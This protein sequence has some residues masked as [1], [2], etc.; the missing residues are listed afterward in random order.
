VLPNPQLT[1]ALRDWVDD[2]DATLRRVLAFLDLPYDPACE[3]F[4]EQDSR[5]RTASRQQVRQPV[6]AR[7]L[8]RWP[9][10]ASGLQ[11]M[12]AELSKAGLFTT[13]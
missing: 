7:G 3:R 6:N 2:F 5:V 10:F 13:P 12:I 1:L 8:D 9:A 4:H 11:P